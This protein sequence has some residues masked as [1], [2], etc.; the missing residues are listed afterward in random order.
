ME[1][2]QH[3]TSHE[4]AV[5]EGES[6][7][8]AQTYTHRLAGCTPTPLA[9]YLKGLAVARILSEQTDPHVRCRWHDEFFEV[10]TSLNRQELI[11]FFLNTY[12][13]T[14]IL[15]PWNGGSGFN[16]KKDSEEHTKLMDTSASRFESIGRTIEGMFELMRSMGFEEKVPKDHK[17]VFL[18]GCRARL[19]D[20]ALP[21]LDAAYVLTGDGATYPPLLGTGGNDGRLDFSRNFVQRLCDLFAVEDGSP[22]YMARTWLEVALF[23]AN[24]SD[25]A[26]KAAIGQFFPYATGGA[27]GESGFESDTLSNPW[28]FIFMLEG[29]TLFAA[30]SVKQL[31][32]TRSSR[33]SAPFCVRHVGIGH[34]SSSHLDEESARAEVWLPLWGAWTHVAQ[35]RQLM[36]EGRLQLG[37]R[38]ARDGVDAARAIS[39]LG[40]ARGIDGFQ[41]F[42]FHERNGRAFLATPLN[43]IEV[44]RQPQVELLQEVDGWLRT[45]R[46]SARD[47]RTPASV[48]RALNQLDEAIFSLCQS[49]STRRFQS[50]FIALGQCERALVRSRTWCINEDGPRNARPVPPLSPR[51]LK[52]ADDGTAEF[53][54]AASLATS[55]LAHGGQSASMR[56]YVEPVIAHEEEHGRARAYWASE[57]ARDVVWHQG[58]P[59]DAMCLVMRRQLI[60]AQ[61]V[62]A[63]SWRGR[64]R[65]PA[66]LKDVA[67]F[68]DGGIDERRMARLFEAL[69]LLNPRHENLQQPW[70][71]RDAHEV[72][73][74]ALYAL[75]KLCFAG[76]K[77]GYPRRVEIPLQPE[78]YRHASSADGLRATRLAVRRLRGSGLRPALDCIAVKGA[79]VRRAAAVLLFPID[80]SAV[81]SLRR[82]IERRDDA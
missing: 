27:N 41:R 32:S 78:I 61:Q 34:S 51:W 5:T 67:A 76:R 17:E 14:P 37:R 20:E 46:R 25:M 48:K 43:R 77:I 30:A 59:L 62:G 79:S 44:K 45:L 12:A 54:L 68:V 73:P 72:H 65:I 53:R 74:G 7:A 39:T 16:L 50:M 75:L 63:S 64:S 33:A 1:S 9:H 36:S 66:T 52:Q 69:I 49:E 81:R 19:P 22:R 57:V 58:D 3:D 26:A 28:D 82:L 21:W 60:H 10:E 55:Y 2:G 56:S 15:A 42:A 47:E 4:P 13:P 24:R 35:L 80:R 71:P 23:D 6:E 31:E 38:A 18:Q 11:D 40:V 8:S 29:A 70:E